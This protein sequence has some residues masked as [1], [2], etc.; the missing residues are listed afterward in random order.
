MWASSKRRVVMRFFE[1]VSN[2][3]LSDGRGQVGQLVE[4]PKNRKNP[5]F[6]GKT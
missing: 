5:T 6:E 1:K 3:R 2:L 4:K